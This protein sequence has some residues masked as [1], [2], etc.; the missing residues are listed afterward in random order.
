MIPYSKPN[1]APCTH[2]GYLEGMI[3]ALNRGQIDPGEKHEE[4]K[5][6]LAELWGVDP[7]WVLLTNSCTLALHIA[8]HRMIEERGGKMVVPAISWPSTFCCDGIEYE[9]S[10]VDHFGLLKHFGVS[11]TVV[12]LWGKRLHK[13]WFEGLHESVIVDSAQCLQQPNM[14]H[15]LCNNGVYAYCFSFGPLKADS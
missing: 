12:A 8:Q 9:F 14:E 6:K 4:F 10:D 1:I 13:E 2:D 7:A 15:C 5:R 3:E 11:T